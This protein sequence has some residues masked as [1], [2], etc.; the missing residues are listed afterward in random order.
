MS[1]EDVEFKIKFMNETKYLNEL[2]LFKNKNKIYILLV[3]LIEIINKENSLI[4]F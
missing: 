3:L 1:N 2:A 4:F